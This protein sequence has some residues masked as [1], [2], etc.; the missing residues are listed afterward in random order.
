MSDV[1]TTL[2]DAPTLDQTADNLALH[3]PQGRA[4]ESKSIEGTNLR[5]LVKASALPF[6]SIEQ[7]VELIAREFD[8]NQTTLLIDEW[9]KSV[10]L[11]DTCLGPLIDIEDRRALVIERLRKRAVVTLEELQAAIDVIFPGVG[12]AL[13]AGTD[14]YTFEYSFELDFIGGI[15]ERFVIVA[16][17]PP[18]NPQFEYSFEFDFERGVDLDKLRCY[19]RK[20]IPG[21]VALVI[22]E[23]SG[24]A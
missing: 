6:N 14:Y 23:L 2:L 1:K 19:L 12:I 15:N 24:N 7:I 18:Q 13:Y 16:T 10:G 17:V 20:I 11:P 8:I 21:N 4:W 22:E 9:E 3:L 5:A